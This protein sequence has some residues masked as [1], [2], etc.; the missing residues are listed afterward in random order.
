LDIALV[1]ELR[2]VV[3]AYKVATY[4]LPLLFQQV[5]AVLPA[6]FTSIQFIISHTA[7]SA[8]CYTSTAFE[9]YT[10]GCIAKAMMLH[11]HVST[12]PCHN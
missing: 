1:A 12:T 4:A 10:I 11:H 9:Q 8:W 6:Q 3:P 2:V 5:A 7:A